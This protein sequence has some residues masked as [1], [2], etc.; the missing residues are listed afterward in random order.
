M[1]DDSLIGF[2]GLSV[3][4]IHHT[5]MF[6]SQRAAQ[7]GYAHWPGLTAKLKKPCA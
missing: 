6:D 2:S 3:V 7:Y 5:R 1:N 4:K